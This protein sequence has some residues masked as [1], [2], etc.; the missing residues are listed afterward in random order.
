VAI[1]AGA[2][3]FGLEAAGETVLPERPGVE[4]EG[5]GGI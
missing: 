4:R 1:A 3:R 5:R 2:L